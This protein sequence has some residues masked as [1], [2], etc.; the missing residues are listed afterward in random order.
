MKASTRLKRTLHSPSASSALLLASS[1]SCSSREVAAD[2]SEEPTE[3]D[4]ALGTSSPISW[5]DEPLRLDLCLRFS[6][7]T[8]RNASPR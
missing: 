3:L 8:C 6:I 7:K 2:E 5:R 4:E 1:R